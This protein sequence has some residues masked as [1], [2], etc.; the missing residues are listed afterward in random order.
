MVVDVGDLGRVR[1]GQ[2]RAEI[3]FDFCFKTGDAP[4]PNEVLQASLL[5][6]LAV[7]V[8]APA[9]DDGFG[10]G[11]GLVDGHVSHL[12]PDGRERF[13]L[14]RCDSLT[15]TDVHVEADQLVV[16]DDAQQTEVVGEDVDAVVFRQGETDLEFSR[17]VQLAVNWF[18]DRRELGDFLIVAV[19]VLQP[20]FLIGRRV[21]SEVVSQL[22]G[23]LLQP[24]VYRVAP[25]RSRAAHDVAVDV[26]TGSQRG[27][28]RFTDR[29]DRGLQVVLHDAVQL[30]SLA[31]GDAQ[32]AVAEF[33]AHVE[34]SQQA[35]GGQLPAGNPR[36]DH[37]HVGLAGLRAVVV[38]LAAF[39]PVVLLVGAVMFEEAD[40]G[41]G[42][43]LGFRI[44]LLSNGTS[45]LP[46][47]AFQN[48]DFA[49]F[50][51]FGHGTSVGL[52]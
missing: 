52:R 39:V 26:A 11:D 38:F 10:E 42:E 32:R 21:R 19:L 7:A 14:S 43:T 24:G 1:L 4:V 31:A 44:E 50:D 33:L 37:H 36:P 48:L 15:A 40:V 29:P 30:Q 25:D 18:F 45:K 28:R 27:E 23:D 17:Q 51:F 9:F 2:R 6:V 13:L 22:A 16:L 49:E 35:V 41:S 47:V 34:L 5:A 20:D 12:Q 3:L 46:A 8:V